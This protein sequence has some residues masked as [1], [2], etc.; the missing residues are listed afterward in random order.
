MVCVD[1]IYFHNYVYSSFPKY[2]LMW[3]KCPYIKWSSDFAFRY[4]HPWKVMCNGWQKE[5]WYL[6]V[7]V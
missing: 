3:L 5:Y 6:E 1:G 2:I 7:C 4:S